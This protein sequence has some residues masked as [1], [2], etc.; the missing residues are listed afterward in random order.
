MGSF[1]TFLGFAQRQDL[2]EKYKEEIDFLYIKK[3]F[4]MAAQ[5]YVAN[6]LKPD[7]RVFQD[8]LFAALLKNV[9]D[10]A[11]NRYLKKNLKARTMTKWIA[12]HPRLA[13]WA[14]K[15]RARKNAPEA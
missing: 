13:L 3:A 8:E 14:L 10:Y 5:T 15:R 1:D 4:L 12:R 11:S 7:P 6:E 2:Y 9:P